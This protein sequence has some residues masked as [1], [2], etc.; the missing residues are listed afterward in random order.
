MINIGKLFVISAPSGSGKTTLCKKLIEVFNSTLSYSISY[1][2]RPPR[3]NEVDGRDYYF[4]DLDTFKNMIVKDEFLEWAKVYN[5]Y[6]GTAKKQIEQILSTNK[7]V[8]LDIDPQGAMQVKSKM[9]NA[10]LIMILPPRLSVLEERLRMR[11]TESE[12]ELRVRLGNAKNEILN[13]KHYDYIVINDNVDV[14]FKELTSIYIAEHC[15]TVDINDINKII[16]LED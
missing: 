4:V 11:N 3:K 6:Y 14:A 16:M 2:T 9:K 12:A 1:T 10:V 7:D 8:V 5:D 13:Y 15:K